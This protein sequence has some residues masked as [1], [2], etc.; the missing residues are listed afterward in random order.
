MCAKPFGIIDDE[1]LLECPRTSCSQQY[2]KKCVDTIRGPSPE[3][4]FVCTACKKN[5]IPECNPL[6]ERYLL[7]KKFSKLY[8]VENF[9][10]LNSNSKLATCQ[11]ILN[12]I[13][14]RRLHLQQWVNTFQ[15]KIENN[16]SIED[17][18]SDQQLISNAKELIDKVD[19]IDKELK[20]IKSVM[21]YHS[22]TVNDCLEIYK[23]VMK[24]FGII[25]EILAKCVEAIETGTE[26][27]NSGI[28]GDRNGT[29]RNEYRMEDLAKLSSAN[30]IAAIDDILLDISF[31]NR[32]LLSKYELCKSLLKN[33]PQPPTSF[34]SC[35]QKAKEIL[36]T[37]ATIQEKLNILRGN[38]RAVS[39]CIDKYD[40]CL[41]DE[42]LADITCSKFIIL[43][44]KLRRKTEYIEMKTF[45]ST[46]WIT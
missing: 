1:L 17:S 43:L 16:Q 5:V 35:L 4:P 44:E 10:N 32:H 9:Q 36:H 27:M 34:D 24:K 3:H 8:G 11:T 2:C 45:S 28:F 40:A 19:E 20:D 7:W 15:K 21:K 23:K 25:C 39:R 31:R 38:L 41:R 13:N 18:D 6:I 22:T 37:M 29:I 12:D 33:K 30:S 42:N 26:I 14:T 46:Y